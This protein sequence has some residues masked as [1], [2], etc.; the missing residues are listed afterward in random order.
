MVMSYGNYKRQTHSQIVQS[1]NMKL[2]INAY[3]FDHPLARELP[4]SMASE[5]TVA[6]NDSSEN[7]REQPL[8]NF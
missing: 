1:G 7:P 5:F 6:K 3:P 2:I 8:P 4:I